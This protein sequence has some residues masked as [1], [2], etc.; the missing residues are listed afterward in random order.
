MSTIEEQIRA[1]EGRLSARYDV[2]LTE[3]L[4]DLKVEGSELRIRVLEAGTGPPIVLLHPAFW[5]AA[6]WVPC[7]LCQRR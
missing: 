4:L 3:H 1:A 2:S 7:P 5:F 6:Q